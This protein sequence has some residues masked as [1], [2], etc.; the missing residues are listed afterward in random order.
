[1]RNIYILLGAI[2]ILL[3]LLYLNLKIS[4]DIERHTI[5]KPGCGSVKGSCA[6]YQHSHCPSS[7]PHAYDGAGITGGYCC[8]VPGI[9]TGL[10]GDKLDNCNTSNYIKCENPPCKN[11]PMS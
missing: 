10:Y 5:Y 9:S 3:I 4:R 7:N 11:A 2:V 1:M 8:D 6:T